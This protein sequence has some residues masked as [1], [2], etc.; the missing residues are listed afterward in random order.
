MTAP[1]T[2]R[3]SAAPDGVPAIDVSALPNY[4][5]GHRSLLWWGTFGLIAIEGTVFALTVVAYFYLRSRAPQWPLNG[6]PPALLWGTVNTLVMLVSL[7]PNQWA[8]RAA[9]AHRLREVRIAL[10][11][12]M[13]FSFAFLGVRVLEFQS[14][15]VRWDTDAYGS[16]VWLLLG[17]HTV[18]LL[19]DTY[20]S[21]VLTVLMFTGP[22]EG[23]RMADVN[24]NAVYWYF[25]VLSWLAIYAVIYVAPR[26]HG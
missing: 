8:K 13:A 3:K 1:D 25:V 5:F 4:A 10:V 12:C 20:D 23:R 21:G 15:N 7:V 24:E 6:V 18:H 2:P 9:E 16:I 11:I 19:T 17:L 14:L 22:L 26:V